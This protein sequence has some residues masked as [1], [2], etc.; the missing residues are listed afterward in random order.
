METNK[1]IE[2]NTQLV[3]KNRFLKSDILLLIK[4]IRGDSTKKEQLQEEV[5]SLI[6]SYERNWQL[7]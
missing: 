4:Y 3:D 7:K 5:N 2:A 1:L 6:E